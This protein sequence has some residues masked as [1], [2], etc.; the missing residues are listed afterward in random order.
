MTTST[1]T[2]TLEKRRDAKGQTY[3]RGKIWL[4]DGSRARI[5]ID[6]PKCYS[7][8]AARD[9]VAFEQEKSPRASGPCSSRIRRNPPAARSSASSHDAFR[10]LSPSRTSGSVS[11]TY[12]F[13]Q[14]SSPG[15]ARSPRPD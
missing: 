7:E 10:S 4:Q 6:E 8:K 9:F 3:Y 11:L 13:M 2:G 12:G 1:R 15:S 14:A 5:E